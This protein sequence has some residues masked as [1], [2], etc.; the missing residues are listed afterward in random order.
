[1]A[2]LIGF[3]Q[4]VTLGLFLF[5]WSVHASFIEQT[6]GAA[7]VKDAT[8]V[9]FNPAAL[10]IIPHQQLILLGTLA[11]AQSQF[12]GSA[13]QV[14]FGL[15]EYGT[16]TTKSNFSLPSMYVSFPINDKFA[17]GFAIV[18]ND[19]NRDLDDHSVLRYVLARN[20]TNDVDLVPGIGIK[21]NEFLSI[22]G[23]LN[24][25]HAHLIQEPVSG[26]TRLNIPDSRSHNNSKANS[27]GGDLGILIQL[28]K[29]TTLGFNYRSAVTYH[30]H[31]TSTITSPQFIASDDFHFKFWTPARSVIS[32]SH[33][34]N[35]KLGFIGTIQYLQ[36]DIFKE[37]Y[38]YNFATQ[39]GRRAFIV[40]QARIDY[41][42]HNSWLLTL[43]TIYNMSSKWKVR[44]AGTY[45]QSPSNGMFQIGTGDSLTVG[46]SM[47]YQLLENLTIDF[48]YGHAFYQ[49]EIINIRTAQNIITGVYHGTHDA[50]SLKLTLTA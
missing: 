24:I 20:Q 23:N 48:S 35:E 25:T 16:V 2:K 47:G 50:V 37:A 42:F 27:L 4:Y 7:V 41:N 17:A 19:F 46:S 11:R 18:A 49:K 43:G 45:N 38:I 33:F 29:S 10:T 26:V 1:M 5:C 9:Y 34:L 39:S 44:V 32:L 30:F 14:P 21:I 8:A 28:S 15:T 36:W 3:K 13:Q 22:G 6:L 31:G 40:P 12:T